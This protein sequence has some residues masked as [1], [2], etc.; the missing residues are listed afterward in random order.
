L[1]VIFVASSD[2]L[3]AA[4]VPSAVRD[5]SLRYVRI[6][7]VEALSPAMEVAVASSTRALD[8][9]DVPLLISS[10]KFIVNIVLDLLI[11]S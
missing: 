2:K 7:S 1:T 4:F 10:I 8:H 6:S 3:A 11:I 9:P 5:T